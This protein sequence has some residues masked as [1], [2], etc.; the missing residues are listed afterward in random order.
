MSQPR[1]PTPGSN[2]TSANTPNGSTPDPSTEAA[3]STPNGTPN[4]SNMDYRKISTPRYEQGDDITAP[5]QVLRK[6]VR[7]LPALKK[8]LILSFLTSNPALTND[9]ITLTDEELGNFDEFERIML[10]RHSRSMMQMSIDY[11]RMRQ[12]ENESHFAYLSRMKR[13]WKSIRKWRDDQGDIPAEDAPMLVAKFVRTVRDPRVSLHLGMRS[14]LTLDNLV[15]EAEC[16][17][18]SF[19]LAKYSPKQL[20]NVQQSRHEQRLEY[21]EHDYQE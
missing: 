7:L 9:L 16:I 14:H 2:T 8:Q 20:N 11:E 17:S 6:L 5:L 15:D 12:A 4:K 3:A 18:C 1:P 10:K 21:I 13:L 19:E